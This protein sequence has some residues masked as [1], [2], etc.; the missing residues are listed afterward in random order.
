MDLS[1]C[2]CS[3][4]VVVA[5]GGDV[6]AFAQA[7]RAA[8]PLGAGVKGARQHWLA[9]LLC[10]RRTVVTELPQGAASVVGEQAGV[11]AAGRPA[12][13]LIGAEDSGTTRAK[14]HSLEFALCCCLTSGPVRTVGAHNPKVAGYVQGR[15]NQPLPS[16]H[17]P[18]GLRRGGVGEGACCSPVVKGAAAASSVAPR[19]ALGDDSQPLS[20][21]RSH[22]LAKSAPP[23]RASAAAAWGRRPAARPC[24]GGGGSLLRSLLRQLPLRD[25][26]RPAGTAILL[27]RN[28]YSVRVSIG[29]WQAEPG[30]RSV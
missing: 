29:A 16:P 14:G 27:A 4:H 11:E 3:Q 12:L 22:A 25:P 8:S 10:A 15:G 18:L 28:F 5:V 1:R 26:A 19:S 30:A 13:V 9:V 23:V 24:E 21:A 20:S 6:H 2:F 17:L 7:N